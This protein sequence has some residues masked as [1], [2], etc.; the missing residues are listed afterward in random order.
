MID[1]LIRCL[2]CDRVY[3][4]E[5]FTDFRYDRSSGLVVRVERCPQCHRKPKKSRI[6]TI[7]RSG[8]HYAGEAEGWHPDTQR[9]T[10]IRL[11]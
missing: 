6:E 9:R 10:L 4:R 2:A 7:A 5:S 1:T 11:A 8:Y 3:M